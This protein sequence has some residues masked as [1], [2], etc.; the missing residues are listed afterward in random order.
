MAYV[1]SQNYRYNPAFFTMGR[2]IREGVIGKIGQVKIDFYKGADFGAGNFRHAMEFP[3]LVDMSIHHF[4]L[5]RFLTGQDAVSVRGSSWNPSWSNYA[6]DCSSTALFTMDQG[7]RVLYNASWC[8][9]GNFTDWNGT[10][11][12]EGEKGSLIYENGK[13]THIPVEGLYKP[14]EAVVIESDPMELGG[15]DWVLE[16]VRT[17]LAAGK[18]PETEC[19]DNIKS[20]GMVFAAVEATRTGAEVQL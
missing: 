5:I 14:G 19:N 7:A 18:T 6:G 2:M 3:V 16:N 9:K 13:V 12:I 4:D 15:Q 8:C 17:S 1:V 10:W 11:L 20:V